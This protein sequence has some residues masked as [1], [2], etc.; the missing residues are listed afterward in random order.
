[1]E[2]YSTFIKISDT[3]SS[4]SFSLV[5]K[6]YMICL[7]YATK[8]RLQSF[9]FC[10][11]S[12]TRWKLN[13]GSVVSWPLEWKSTAFH[14]GFFRF[15]LFLLFLSVY[16]I[17][18]LLILWFF[19]WNLLNGKGEKRVFLISFIKIT[20][21]IQKF[22][23]PFHRGLESGLCVFVFH[24]LRT[25]FHLFIVYGLINLFTKISDHNYINFFPVW[26]FLKE[27]KSNILIGKMLDWKIWHFLYCLL[28]EVP[29]LVAV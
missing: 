14:G 28:H 23:F 5:G 22:F 3:I 2:S 13:R 4:F 15:G 20:K 16:V 9:C 10:L 6:M 21:I 29:A 24:L 1:M 12:C 18:Y 26:F 19:F 25:W 17:V 8:S 7:E 27:N 11:C